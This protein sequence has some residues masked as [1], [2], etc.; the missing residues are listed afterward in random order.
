MS[1]DVSV[2]V[3]AGYDLTDYQTDKYEDFVETEEYDGLTCY[4]SKG[5]IQLFDDPMSG[6]YLRLGYIYGN[7]DYIW[8]DTCHKIRVEDFDLYI[9][10]VTKVRNHLIDIGVISEKAYDAPYE[11]IVFNEFR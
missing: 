9:N 1:V 4:Q 7:F 2:Y 3:I 11:V 8:S 10:D 6:N 5:K